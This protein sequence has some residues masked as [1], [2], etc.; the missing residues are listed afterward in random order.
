MLSPTSL[1]NKLKEHLI[2]SATMEVITFNPNTLC[3]ATIIRVGGQMRISSIEAKIFNVKEAQVTI[4]KNKSSNLL[5]K[6]NFMPYEM[7]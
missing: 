5:M 2:I 6:S 3:R 4:I 7:R 1:T